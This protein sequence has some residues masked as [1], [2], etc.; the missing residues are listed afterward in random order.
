MTVTT[1]E[2]IYLT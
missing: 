1:R 2:V